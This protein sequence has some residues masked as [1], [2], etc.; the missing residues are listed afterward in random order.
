MGE[1]GIE[2]SAQLLSALAT[3][4]PAYWKVL[5]T[6]TLAHYQDWV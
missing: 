1:D 4:W 6:A 3:L 2:G 5:T